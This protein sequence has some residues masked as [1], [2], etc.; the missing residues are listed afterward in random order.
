MKKA[1]I[2]GLM[3]VLI[4][5]SVLAQSAARQ[6]GEAWNEHY[7]DRVTKNYQARIQ[8]N[9]RCKA[10]R[11]Q[12]AANSRRHASAASGQ[13]ML[14]MQAVIDGAKADSCLH[15]V[16]PDI[17]KYLEARPQG[18][19]RSASAS[20]TVASDKRLSG[21]ERLKRACDEAHE[22]NRRSPS[23]ENTLNADD[24][25]SSYESERK[26]LTGR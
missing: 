18:V 23:R 2:G 7:R 11:D 10:Y 20:P 1:L 6:I 12:L 17:S 15:G 5:P 14:D 16:Q 13:Y 24:A 21:L 4:S 19:T 22:R 25:C 26:L 8:D 3:L 9:T